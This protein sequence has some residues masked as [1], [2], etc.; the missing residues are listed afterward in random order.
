MLLEDSSRD[1]AGFIT[2]EIRNPRGG[3][4]LEKEPLVDTKATPVL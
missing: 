1:T 4:E 3:G 2:F